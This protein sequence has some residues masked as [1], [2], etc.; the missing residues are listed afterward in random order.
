MSRP[1]TVYVIEDDEV[2]RRH[3]LESV[4]G[5]DG[6][7]VVGEAGSATDARR[8]LASL[9]ALDVLLT[10]LKLP[11]GHGIGS[12]TRAIQAG[13]SG[14]VLK[15]GSSLEIAQALRDLVEGGSPLSP[16]VARYL[17]EL[18]HNPALFAFPKASEVVPAR[19]APD[20]LPKLSPREC[21]VLELLAK[22][23][24]PR[25][26]GDLL[27]ISAHTVITHTRAIHRKLEVS[28]RAAAVFEALSLGLIR[29]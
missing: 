11:D 7:V 18:A 16:R 29:L 9:P 13:A 26:I 23:F 27:H 24:S 22:G 19:R 20:D 3:L 1:R 14:Y 28:T 4:R 8:D 25:E 6:F 12:V 15:G 2:T 10:D 5:A 21:E 17:L